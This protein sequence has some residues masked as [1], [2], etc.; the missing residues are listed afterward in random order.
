MVFTKIQQLSINHYRESL[1]EIPTKPER[2][3][4]I[5]FW[6]RRARNETRR[7]IIHA[8]IEGLNLKNT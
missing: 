4:L 2:Q 5:K 7:A 6:L 8:A 1:L 3:N